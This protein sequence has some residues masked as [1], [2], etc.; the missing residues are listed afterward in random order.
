M[1]L[2]FLE[3]IFDSEII[4]EIFF[5]GYG[6]EVSVLINRVVVRVKWVFVLISF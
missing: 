2:V 4:N 6:V 3:I 5:R 1:I